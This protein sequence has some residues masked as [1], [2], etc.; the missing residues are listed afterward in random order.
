MKESKI[1]LGFSYRKPAIYKIVVQGELDSVW[2][3][4]IGLQIS[5]EKKANKMAVTTMIG[6]ITD[7][8][9]LSGIMVQLNDLQMTVLSVNML[10]EVDN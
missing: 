9:A 2:S 5:I 8:S 10:E 1:S 4:R 3:D 7:Q 6:K